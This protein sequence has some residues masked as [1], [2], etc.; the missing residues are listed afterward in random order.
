MPGLTRWLASQVIAQ[1]AHGASEV[2]V[3]SRVEPEGGES[4][5]DT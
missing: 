1:L 5:A 2:V 4:L 3:A